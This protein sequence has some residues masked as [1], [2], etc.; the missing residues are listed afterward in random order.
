MMCRKREEEIEQNRDQPLRQD[1][2]TP[3][4]RSVRPRGE[5]AEGTREM[6]VD[7][8]SCSGDKEPT[9]KTP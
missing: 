4:R 2:W 9:L 7:S 5:A 1:K 3:E 8:K 6:T